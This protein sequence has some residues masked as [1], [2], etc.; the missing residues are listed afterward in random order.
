M[1][2][3]KCG[4]DEINHHLHG[5]DGSDSNLCD[6][7]YWRK[8]AVPKLRPI[9]DVKRN[10]GGYILVALRRHPYHLEPVYWNSKHNTWMS[11]GGMMSYVDDNIVGY[12]DLPRFEQ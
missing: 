1:R 7:C 12:V 8:R 6:V 9:K 11:V 2:C 10:A 3:E 5:R 4:S